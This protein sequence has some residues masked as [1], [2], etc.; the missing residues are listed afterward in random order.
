MT[1][2][3]LSIAISL[4]ILGYLSYSTRCAFPL[5][6]ATGDLVLQ[7]VSCLTVAVAYERLVGSG[8][9]VSVLS[10]LSSALYPQSSFDLV[11]RWLTQLRRDSQAC[12]L[13]LV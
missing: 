5:P 8:R 2:P 9:A 11:T 6:L 10:R 4:I 3:D 7:L 13:P 12:I 1:I